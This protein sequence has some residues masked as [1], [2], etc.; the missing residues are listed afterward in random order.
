MEDGERVL[1]VCPG[2]L[3][4]R[5][6]ADVRHCGRR[7]HGEGPQVPVREDPTKVSLSSMYRVIQKD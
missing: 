4:L 3:P 6:A 2:P 7:I 5:A 1:P